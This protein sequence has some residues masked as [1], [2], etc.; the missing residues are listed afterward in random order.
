MVEHNKPRLRHELKYPLTFIEH[1]ILRKKLATVLKP[2]SNAGPDGSYKIRSLYFDDFRNTALFEKQSGVARRKKYRIRIYNC[3][4][5]FIRFERKTKLDHYILKDWVRLS[6]KDADK[7]IAGDVNFLANSENVLLRDFY[8]DHR[9]NL[10]R[11]VVMVDYLR[12]AYVHPVGNIRI[13]FDK[14]LHTGLGPMAFFDHECTTTGIH[15]E[16]EIILEIKFDDILPLHIRGLFP[17]TIIPRSA[18]GKFSTC[19]ESAFTLPACSVKR[20]A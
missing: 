6:R 4:D 7:I 1:Q 15:E 16:H 5:Q 9:R 19:R 14:E 18:L 10:L 17:N 11:P 2:D 20:Q 12:E 8:L 13:T 3:S